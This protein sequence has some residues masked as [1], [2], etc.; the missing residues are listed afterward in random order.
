M[1]KVEALR[2]WLFGKRK[3]VHDATYE[4]LFSGEYPDG[5]AYP[6]LIRRLKAIVKAMA[7]CDDPATAEQV[8]NAIFRE[9]AHQFPGSPPPEAGLL[10]FAWL[11]RNRIGTNAF[12]AGGQA[13]VFYTQ[14]P[15]YHVPDAQLRRCLQF[16]FHRG[17][18]RR[19]NQD[20][21]Q[22]LAAELHVSPQQAAALVRQAWHEL[23]DVMKRKFDREQL[24]GWT[25]GYLP[26]PCPEGDR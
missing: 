3:P 6:E 10:R 21:T 4:E 7:Y 14:L 22:E 11:I 12:Y 25:E 1:N 8:T 5:V 17:F 18:N 13:R 19:T 23:C 20:L 9:F 15:L 16:L 2:N 24:K 26:W